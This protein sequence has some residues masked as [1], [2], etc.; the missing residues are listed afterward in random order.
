MRRRSVRLSAAALFFLG[1]A[2]PALAGS[3]MGSSRA[4]TCVKGLV[5]DVDQAERT[6]RLLDDQGRE[7]LIRYDG[8]TLF[9]FRG[10]AER[11][12]DLRKGAHVTV[13]GAAVLGGKGPDRSGVCPISFLAGQVEVGEAL[14]LQGDPQP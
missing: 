10:A 1:A 9:L 14:A 6:I 5:T 2:A 11:R 8:E 12:V 4:E 13:W 7:A 3:P